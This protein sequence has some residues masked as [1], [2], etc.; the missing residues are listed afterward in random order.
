MWYLPMP[1]IYKKQP[2]VNEITILSQG[3]LM[4]ALP[5]AL[6]RC[7]TGQDIAQKTP[8]HGAK[9]PGK[10]VNC[11]KNVFLY[12]KERKKSLTQQ[13]NNTIIKPLI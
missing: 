13:N 5:A 12:Q 2:L 11:D 8:K 10:I 6:W 7:F 4:T 9:Q 3:A 1:A